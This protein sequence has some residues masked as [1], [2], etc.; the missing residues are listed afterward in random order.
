LNGLRI[1]AVV[2]AARPDWRAAARRLRHALIERPDLFD[3]Q[4]DNRRG[5]AMNWYYPVLAGVL[6]GETGRDRI[7]AQW[8]D[9]IVDGRGCL[10]SLDQ[11]WVTVAETCELVAA[12]AGLGE[13][14]RADALLSWVLPM[15]DSDG[16]FWTGVNFREDVI[17]PPDHKTTWTAA[18]VIIAAL[19]DSE[20]AASARL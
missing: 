15:Q 4:G 16:G 19:A 12:L 2:G 3:L 9:F 10:C 1:A 14:A 7:D 5:Y 13:F 20:L 11:P 17:Y 18:G 8:M 6:T